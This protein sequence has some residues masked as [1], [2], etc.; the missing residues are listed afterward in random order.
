MKAE[1]HLEICWDQLLEYLRSHLGLNLG[2]LHAALHLEEQADGEPVA[3]YATRF[4]LLRREMRMAG[5]VAKRPLVRG[6]N[7]EGA[8]LL[9]WRLEVTFGLCKDQPADDMLEEVSYEDLYKLLTA[10]EWIHNAPV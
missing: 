7:E 6:L 9:S 5:E 4:D 10:P 1:G 2:A 3:I 8:S